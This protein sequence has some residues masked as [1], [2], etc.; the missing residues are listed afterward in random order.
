MFNARNQIFTLIDQ[1]ILAEEDAEAAMVAA[2]VFPDDR[3]WRRFIGQ[4]LLW[5]GVLST[6][7][8]IV[9]FVAYNWD[10][11]GRYG[12]FILLE[13]LLVASLLPL[14]RYELRSRIGQFSLLA[15]GIILGALLALFG[16]TYQ[17]GADTWQLFATWAALLLPWVMLGHFEPLW[18]L[19]LGVVNTALGLGVGLL[20][21]LHFPPETGTA[22]TLLLFN[23]VVLGIWE[24]Q[25]RSEPQAH[26]IGSRLVAT[27]AGIAATWLGIWAVIDHHSARLL[28]GA[29]YLLWL[30]VHCRIYRRYLRDLYMLT[31]ACLS[32]II[33]SMTFLGDRVLSRHFEAGGLFIM[34]LA[35]ILSGTAATQWLRKTEARWKENDHE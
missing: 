32:A 4:L 20:G 31:V 14:L 13:G 29:V 6:V 27:A 18:L 28:W 1:G 35:L 10:V 22:A 33:V 25:Q 7:L 16:Q 3:A 8:G 11:L 19:W 21:I 23:A 24:W 34:A 2:G 26:R 17:T 30:G 12:K 5:L 9:F 15:A